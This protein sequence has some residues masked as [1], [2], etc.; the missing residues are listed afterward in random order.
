MTNNQTFKIIVGNISYSTNEET[1]KNHYNKYGNI[2]SAR[3]PLNHQGKSKG[4]A[5]IEFEKEEEGKNALIETNKTNFEGRTIYVSE[6]NE[7]PEKKYKSN[8]DERDNKYDRHRNRYHEYSDDESYRRRRYRED[9]EDRYRRRRYDDDSDEYDDRRRRYYRSSSRDRY[10]DYHRR[11]S[12][13][14]RYDYS[15]ISPPRRR[16]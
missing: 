4:C 14:R 10:E 16:I 7:I 3:I 5:I 6:G 12:S 2:I 13:R 11:S 1:I 8:K 15:P 9:D